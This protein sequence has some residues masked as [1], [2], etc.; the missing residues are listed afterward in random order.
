MM[1]RL[2]ALL[3]TLVM[4][5]AGVGGASAQT[6]YTV[7]FDNGATQSTANWFTITDPKINYNTKYAGTY[8][9]TT[10][11]KGLK[12]QGGTSITFTTSATSKVTIVQSLKSLSTNYVSFD[13]T[14]KTA[15]DR[16]DDATNNVGV[17][18]ITNVA[19][20]DH[21]IKRAGSEMGLLFIQVDE[22][23]VT[24]TEL[25]AP[26]ISFDASTGVV[27]IGA[28]ENAES[29]VYTTDGTDPSAT[30]GTKYTSTFTVEDGTVVKAIA[31]GDGTKYRSSDIASATVLLDNVTIAAPTISSYNGTVALA[32]TTAKATLEY[33]LDGSIYQT[34]TKPFTLTEDKTV[35]ARATRSSKYSDVSTL[36]VTAVAQPEGTTTVMLSGDSIKSGANSSTTVGG[37]TI[38]ITGNAT[39]TYTKQGTLTING[40]EYAAIKLSNGAQNTLTL[41]EGKVAKRLV[42]YSSI[43]GTAETAN[44]WKEVAGTSYESGDG[45]YT[46]FPMGSTG[47]TATDPDVRV[48]SLDNASSVTF[49]SAGQLFFVLAI[50]VA[51]GTAKSDVTLSIDNDG[52]A[53]L[54]Y[55]DR[56][57]TVPANAKAYTYK[58]AQ[59]ASGD[60]LNLSKTYEA[61]SVIPA[62]TAVLVNA[63]EGDYTFTVAATDGVADADNVLKG[64]DGAATTEG[65]T[66]YYMFSNGSKGLGFYW[67]AANG[68]AFQNGAH[69][70]YI[71]YTPSSSSSAKSF[72]AIG[73]GAT[74]GIGSVIAA[75]NGSDDAVFY[76]LSGQRVGKGYKGIVVRNGCKFVNK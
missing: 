68:A 14:A 20:G 25:A 22:E 52:Y 38:A 17:Y 9:G 63:A 47:V 75:D 15:S 2:H 48:Y 5:L 45:A 54:Y 37:Y 50:D 23:A 34:Y 4:C 21:T 51:D 65:G 7:S 12:M 76:N 3:I 31:L 64:T 8:E 49:T 40:T 29:I 35:Y 41:P 26:A 74:T 71:A 28:V 30:N 61:G 72:L 43:N 66:M 57:L 13:G 53:T 27:T 18:T 62:G 56:A 46:N 42:I 10:Y 6:T 60:V 69:K 32:T 1:K 33:S 55:S 73:K 36:A 16:T 39:K 70:A 59:N 58:I 11:S 44:G 67:G 24:T 19:A